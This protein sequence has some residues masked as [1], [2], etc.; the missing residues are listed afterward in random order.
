MDAWAL[1]SVSDKRGLESLAQSLTSHG[2]KL[3]ATSSTA[4]Y[5]K[6]QGFQVKS[7]EDL[8]GFGEILDGRVKTLHPIIYG[9]LLASSSEQHQAQ[10]VA[11]QAP[12]IRVVV[13]NLYP[14]EEAWRAGK[15]DDAL[16]EEIDIGGVS[17]IRA[18]AK[19][20]E[21]V[22][23][24][25]TPDQYAAFV[26]T[27][28]PEQDVSFRRNLAVMAFEH[29]A[30][31]DAVIAQGLA[32]DVRTWP[33]QLVLAG[34]QSTPLRY[35]ENPH[36]SGAFY[37]DPQGGG[38][39]SASVLQGK[40]LSYNNYADADTALRLVQDFALPAVVVVKHQT[41]CA[42]ALADNINEAYQRAHDADPVSIFGG[43]VAVNRPID[44]L[45]AAKLIDLFLEVIIAPSV[46]EE[47]KSILAKK[48]N[49]RVLVVPWTRLPGRDIKGIMGGFLIQE[50]DVFRVP[51]QD[52][53]HAAGPDLAG[54][55]AE[56]D[57][58]VAW[59][60]VARVKSNAIVVAKDGTTLGVAGGQ[61]NRIDA[62]RQALDR[63]GEGARGAVLASDGFFPFGDVLE[64]CRERGIA[65]VVEPGGS[66]RDQESIDM[67]NEAGI[68][69]LLTGE[70]HFRH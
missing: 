50:E 32:V 45:L 8:T 60:T 27:P 44:P 51:I 49:L 15:R 61:T 25:V 39:A 42:A 43:V 59:K 52:W 23:V 65:V 34:R 41:P 2:L 14:F 66:M 4:A 16:V 1:L 6:E 11:M 24:L 56:R 40:A 3:L 54:R 57:L 37:H 13:V 48:K 64:L 7:V 69:L 47:A 68:T 55:A 67:A 31:Y 29:V 58:E 62:A 17:L 26:E 20:H 10:R 63:A 5:L 38:L 9:G 33:D 21:R 35:G 70:R 53:Q 30:Y 18:A 12:D 22:A 19:N 28:W 36:Q 46:E